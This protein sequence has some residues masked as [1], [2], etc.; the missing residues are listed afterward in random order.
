MTCS[1]KAFSDSLVGS[2]TFN[3]F[4]EVQGGLRTP[5]PE[6]LPTRVIKT[7]GSC[8]KME[9]IVLFPDNHLVAFSMYLT[10][11][12]ACVCLC[13][14]VCVCMCVCVRERE[15]GNPLMLDFVKAER[16]QKKIDQKCHR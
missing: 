15:G 13:V 12:M 2:S 5:R 10:K 16:L 11:Q 9:K 4:C 6:V 14:C 3:H 1:H 7:F 8:K